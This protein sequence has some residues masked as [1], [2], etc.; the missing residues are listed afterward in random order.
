MVAVLTKEVEAALGFDIPYKRV[1]HEPLEV[2]DNFPAIEAG[3]LS[4]YKPGLGSAS[5]DNYLLNLKG[6]QWTQQEWIAYRPFHGLTDRQLLDVL[7]ET[8]RLNRIANKVRSS[9]II[10]PAFLLRCP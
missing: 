6:P 10:N 2:L 5:L 3:K 4:F 8:Y 1:I 9:I 7:K